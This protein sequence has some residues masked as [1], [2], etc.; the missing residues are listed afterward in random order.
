MVAHSHLKWDLMPF[1][2]VS[3]DSYSVLKYNKINLKK[4]KFPVTTWWLTAIC[5]GIQ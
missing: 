4:K 1:S 5:N 3:E 2:G